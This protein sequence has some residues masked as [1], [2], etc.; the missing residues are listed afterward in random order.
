[1]RLLLLAHFLMTS[2]ATA[3]SL[4]LERSLDE[5]RSYVEG[6]LGCDVTELPDPT[7]NERTA[8]SV[9]FGETATLCEAENQYFNL[10]DRLRS[11]SEQVR[12]KT[13]RTLYASSLH[14]ASP[15][16][17]YGLSIVRADVLR[18]MLN[19]KRYIATY[20]SWVWNRWFD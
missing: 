15:V 5:V 11:S 8:Y 3:N 16:R 12:Y 9:L 10:V 6:P 13:I 7:F 4:E 14:L 17:A 19:D 2:L 20:A 1:M 18:M